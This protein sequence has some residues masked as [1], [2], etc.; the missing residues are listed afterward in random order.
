MAKLLRK[1][2]TYVGLL[3][4]TILVVFGIAGL[5]VTF[6]GDT[7]DAPAP[8]PESVEVVDFSPPGGLDDVQVAKIAYD[9][10]GYTTGATDMYPQRNADNALVVTFWGPNGKKVA[11]FQEAEKKL[12]VETYSTGT[13]EFLSRMHTLSY[14]FPSHNLPLK[15]WG[16]YVELSMVSLLFM[17]VT[18]FYLWVASR[19]RSLWWA[20]ASLA[21]SVVLSVVTFVALR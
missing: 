11:T 18:G 17:T 13:S 4:F 6:H 3:N 15:L 2:H 1:L 20:Q 5:Y 14:T 9:Q 7:R 21:V 12:R 16:V 19:R 10:L 8:E